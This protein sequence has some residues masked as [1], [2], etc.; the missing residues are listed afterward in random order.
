MPFPTF[1]KTIEERYKAKLSH[2]FLLYFNINDMIYDDIYGYLYTR[3]YLL[4]RM[5]YLGCDAVLYYTR[6]EGLLFP[7]V[8]LRDAYQ[9]AY[10][11]TRI[12][13]IEPLPDP[14]EGQD[15]ITIRNINSG[16]RKVGEETKI[17][18]EPQEMMAM[19]EKFFKQGLGDLRV[20]ILIND[21]DKLLPNRRNKPLSGQEIADIETWQRWSVDLQMRSRGHVILLLTENISNVAPELLVSDG[22][23]PFP[24][25]IPM[26]T[27]QERL[28][29][30]RHLLYIPELEGQEGMYKLDLPEGMLS[31][32][33]SA[34]THGL[35]ILD[36][37]KLWITGKTR[38]T[39][40][41]PTMVVQQNRE[42][43]KT[44]SYGRLELVYGNHGLDTV[45]G[46][47]NVINYIGNVINS[48]KN[49][50]AKS[51]PKGILMVGP[52]GT[53]KTNLI[54][55]LGRDMGIHIVKLCGLRGNEPATHGDWD[56]H[57]ALD[58]IHSLTPVIAFVDDIDKIGYY[59]GTDENERRLINQLMDDLLRFMR[60]PLLRGRVLW[61]GAT[62]RPDLVNPEFRKQG[63]L[64]DVIPFL[65]PDISVREDILRKIFPRNAIPY[66]VNINFGV[67]SGKTERCTGGDLELLMMRSF[68]NAHLN[69]RDIVID[70]D[71]IK[72]ADEFIPPRD[73]NLDEYLMLIAI[74]E[75]SISTLVPRQLPGALNERVFENNVINKAK[76]NQRIRELEVLLN[77]QGRK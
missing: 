45:G 47:G 66:D 58:I 63:T 49:W 5:N 76:I 9:S 42:S 54:S 31:E 32:E 17:T 3:D 23:S 40:V 41:S 74:R 70:A 71:L 46:L 21:I 69:S 55:A 68:Q 20:G 57:R 10:K 24:V 6:S 13:E 1:W 29:F 35:N 38:K 43:I 22:L 48:L 37:Q 16:L 50:D 2:Q 33:F 51:V 59:T 73:A 52:P 36:I 25:E 7:N 62:N 18:R 65:I 39:V 77:I 60:D 44:R 34:S 26:P 27:Y 30:I 19:V 15:S 72:S 75:A 56:L 28:A 8:V 11:L 67:I 61:I 53:G 12:E 4:E 14:P 64:D